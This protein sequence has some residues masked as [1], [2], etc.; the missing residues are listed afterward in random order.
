[1]I[2]GFPP[3]RRYSR[4]ALI[5]LVA[6]RDAGIAARD[7]QITV[8]AGKLSELMEASDILAGKSSQA[9]ASAVA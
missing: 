4:D 6:D 1:L 7:A 3:W 8:R 9:G 5:T 2:S